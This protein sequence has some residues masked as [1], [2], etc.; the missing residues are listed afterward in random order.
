MKRLLSL[1]LIMW[2]GTV[3]AQNPPATSTP[4]QAQGQARQLGILVGGTATQYDLCAQKGFLPKSDPSAEDTAK[5]MLERMNT[6]GPDLSAYMKDG[7]DTFKKELS[8][9]ESFFTREKCVGVG[10][11]W[12]RIVSTMQQK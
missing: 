9:H 4:T 6:K 10:K 1:G 12:G 3:S 11:E 8:G 2:A 5:A 7:W